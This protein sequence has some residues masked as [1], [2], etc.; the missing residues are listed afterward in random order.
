MEYDSFQLLF[1]CFFLVVYSLLV[2]RQLVL[3]CVNMTK[4]ALSLIL[5]M[6]SLINI[7]NHFLFENLLRSTLLADTL[8]LHFR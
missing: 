8:I 1:V 3:I 7:S 2:K 5:V 6:M 4:S